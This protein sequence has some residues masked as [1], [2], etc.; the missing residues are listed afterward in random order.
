[1]YDDPKANGSNEKRGRPKEATKDFEG[2]KAKLRNTDLSEPTHRPR[3]NDIEISEQRQA[4]GVKRTKPVDPKAGIVD[5][6]DDGGDGS[7]DFTLRR[8]KKSNIV[9]ITL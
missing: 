6:E 5:P 8:E 9:L 4:S 2:A 3:G 1:M 7:T